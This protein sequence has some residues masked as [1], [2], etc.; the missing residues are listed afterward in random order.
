MSSSFAHG[1]HDIRDFGSSNGIE[2]R[3]QGKGAVE[4]RYGGCY[5]GYEDRAPGGAYGMGGYGRRGYPPIT[6]PPVKAYPPDPFID[7]FTLPEALMAGTLFRW[8]YDSY[9][10]R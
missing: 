9:V 5:D 4:A 6:L 3:Y 10:S 2:A 7:Q 1:S 8:L